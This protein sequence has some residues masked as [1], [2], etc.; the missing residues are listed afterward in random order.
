MI[1]HHPVLLRTFLAESAPRK[2]GA[3]RFAN[4]TTR[5]SN[6]LFFAKIIYEL[7]A[8]YIGDWF[9]RLRVLL[10]FFDSVGRLGESALQFNSSDSCTVKAVWM[11]CLVGRG[12]RREN[13]TCIAGRDERWK[14]MCAWC[15]Y[16]INIPCGC[17]PDG[18]IDGLDLPWFDKNWGSGSWSAQREQAWGFTDDGLQ[19]LIFVLRRKFDRVLSSVSVFFCEVWW[20]WWY[21]KWHLIFWHDHQREAHIFIKAKSEIN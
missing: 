9:L 5:G 21:L 13:G 3:P 20:C 1:L 4:I 17:E 10:L 6:V 2:I 15:V 19:W 12:R 11:I 8:I 7:R 14:E 16:I 18:W